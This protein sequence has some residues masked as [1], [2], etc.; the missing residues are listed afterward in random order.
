M[1]PHRRGEPLT[2]E[3]RRWYRKIGSMG[4]QAGKGT[5]LRREINR[6]AS[7]IRWSAVKQAKANEETELRKIFTRRFSEPMPKIGLK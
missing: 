2:E 5:Q 3:A 1:K 6:R 4:G 7:L